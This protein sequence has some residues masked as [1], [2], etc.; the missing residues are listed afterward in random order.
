MT[1]NMKTIQKYSGVE[2]EDDVNDDICYD[3][4]SDP[5]WVKYEVCFWD[6]VSKDGDERRLHAGTDSNIIGI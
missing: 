1:L 4:R 2:H 5:R 3:G 6:D